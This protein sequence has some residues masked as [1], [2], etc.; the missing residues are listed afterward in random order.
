MITLPT[1]HAT[2]GSFSS[3]RSVDQVFLAYMDIFL[4]TEFFMNTSQF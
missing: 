4:L 1:P 3:T 2:I